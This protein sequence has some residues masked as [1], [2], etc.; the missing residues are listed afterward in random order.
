MK[1][2]KSLGVVLVCRDYKEYHTDTTVRFVVKMTPEKLAHAQGQGLHKVFKL[3]GSI[4]T[5]CMV[6]GG[7]LG[8]PINQEQP[9]RELVVHFE[10]KK[11]HPV[12]WK[13]F[14]LMKFSQS[15]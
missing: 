10:K 9:G 4:T 1:L 8:I 7:L 2:D 15:F 6:S 13:S 5:G 14:A 3:Q 12:C 11:K